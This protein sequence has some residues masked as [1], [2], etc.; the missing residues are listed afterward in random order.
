VATLLQFFFQS[1]GFRWPVVEVIYF[2]LKEKPPASA[3][4]KILKFAARKLG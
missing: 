2:A 1:R 4:R 3:A